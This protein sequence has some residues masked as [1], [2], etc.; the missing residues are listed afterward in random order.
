[1][2]LFTLILFFSSFF[3]P[4]NFAQERLGKE[5]ISGIVVDSET[6]EPIEG[7]YLSI[8]KLSLS[9]VT[10]RKGDF[11]FRN[12]P[13][14]NH[15][16]F[17]FHLGY[18]S[19]S[20]ELDAEGDGKYQF[21]W[22][23]ELIPKSYTFD[24]LMVKSTRAEDNSPFTYSNIDKEELEAQNLGQDV[25]YLLRW[26]PSTVVTSDAGAGIGYTGI[27]IR[28]SDPSRINVT[29]NGIP[30]ND[31]ESQLV[32]WVNMP[33]FASSTEDI[34]IQRGVGTSTNGAGAFG[35]TVNL[36][37]NKVNNKFAEINTSFGSFGTQKYNGQFSTGLLNQ[38]FVFDGRI[39]YLKSDGYIDRASS[40][41]FSWYASGAYVGKKSSLRV[42]A[43]SGMERTYQAWC[44]VPAQYIE[45][46]ELRTFNPC[47]IKSDGSFYED[48]VDD[49]GQTHFQAIYNASLA[50]GLNLNL[51]GHYT[52]GQGFFEQWE[53]GEDFG[54]YPGLPAQIVAGDTMT[55]GDLV[56]RRWL[57]NDFYGGTF[58]LNY[59][60][61]NGRLDLTPGA[62]Y[63]IYEGRHFGEVLF[64]EFT[65]FRQE[66]ELPIYYDNFATKTDLNFFVKLKYQLAPKFAGF[67]DL[68]Q[69][70]VGYEFEG[71]TENGEFL[72][73]EVSHSFFNP[74]FG[75]TFDLDS[76][77]NIYAS[78]AQAYREPNRNDYTET[79]LASRPEVE[80]L[81]DIEIGFRKNWKKAAFEV[82]GYL[83]NYKDQLVLNGQINDVGEYS[84]VN[85]PES[86]RRGIELV[87]GFQI[88]NALSFEGNATFSQ[89]KVSEFTEFIDDWSDFTQQLPIDHEDTDLAFSPNIILGG[90]LTYEFL[91]NNLDNDLKVSLL[92]KHIGK[93]FIDNTSLDSR[94]LDAYT[95]ADLRFQYTFKSDLLKAISVN[96]LIQ[97]V[98]D[99]KFS[100][101]AWTYHFVS[102][103]YD[104]RPDDATARAESQPFYNLTGFYPQAGRNFLLGLKIRI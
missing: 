30:V 10:R 51:A 34:Q 52:L 22:K 64:T 43:F 44:G 86:F 82:T 3:L 13:L 83:M 101:N 70:N 31:A 4:E 45:D 75:L 5:K 28:G 94:S 20:F 81:R 100:T 60:S 58:S 50:K 6:G 73:Q 97:N 98:L 36:N 99:S 46:S 84:R 2:R 56:R 54:D 66:S 15:K 39:S 29:I 89:N 78:F 12:L 88:T 55:S 40:D 9:E 85:I 72:P 80:R 67:I 62:G 77:T 27:R 21:D 53:N 16:I 7:V 68:Q 8:N 47:G 90:G 41:L 42:N 63:N 65:D 17:V 48:Q 26:Q 23:I 19:T 61:P 18:E 71:P 103:G 76:T 57:D 24:E 74:K 49:Y 87:G 91:K 69:R 32:F 96:F 25:P 79:T 104:P 35:G 95:F 11:V 102:P 38:K 33:D 1:M 93:Q 14:E 59:K 92:G 37:T